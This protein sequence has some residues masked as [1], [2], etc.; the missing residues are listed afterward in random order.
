LADSTGAQASPTNIFAAASTPAHS[1]FELS[2]FVLAV[3]AVIFLVVF[4]LL[5][6][7]DLKFRK[8]LMPLVDG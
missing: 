1:I 2:L 3:T 6:Y 7:A 8:P 4:N 5:V